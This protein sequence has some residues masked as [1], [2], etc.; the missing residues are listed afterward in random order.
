MH[1]GKVLKEVAKV[2][3]SR[4]LLTPPYPPTENTTAISHT[5]FAASPQNPLAKP[6]QELLTVARRYEH[7]GAHF[8]RRARRR[9]P[10]HQ[11]RATGTE[12]ANEGRATGVVNSSFD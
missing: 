10:P 7:N 12:I 9:A 3:D 11:R 5:A 2:K 6:R 4:R 8:D 1:R